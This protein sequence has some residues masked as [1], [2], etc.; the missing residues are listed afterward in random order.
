MLQIRIKNY[1]DTEPVI[2]D[3]A[4][5]RVYSTAINSADEGISFEIAKSDP[6]SEVVNPNTVGYTKLWEV[7]DTATNKRLNYGPISSIDDNIT[8]WKVSGGGRS[9]L[10]ADFIT[11][12]KTFYAPIY[13]IIEDISYENLAAQPRTTTLVPE[14]TTSAAQTTVFGNTVIINERYHGLSKG[15]KDNA[16]DDNLGLFKPGELE[17]PNTYYAHDTFWSGMDV[18]DSHIVDLGDVYDVHRI[19]YYLPVWGG[20]RKAHNRAYDY[21]VAI[22]TDDAPTTSL[23][24]REFGTFITIYTSDVPNRVIGGVMLYIGMN[25][26]S[27]QAV[28]DL[29]PTSPTVLNLP[30][31]PVRY[32]RI[33]ISDTHAWYGTH[34]DTLAATDIW[35]YECDPDYVEG[36]IPSL[37]PGPSIGTKARM[38]EPINERVL[39]P[40]NDCHAS[41]TEV[42]VNKEIV[43]INEIK[44][45]AL[46]RIDNNNPQIQYSYSPVSGK[47]IT[48]SSGFRKFEPGSLFRK[49]KVTYSGA[50]GGYT[51][52]FDSDCTNCYPDGFNFGIMDQNNSL[53]YATDTGSGTNVSRTLGAYTK[54]ILMKG[55]SN[56]VVTWCDAWPARSDPLSWGGSYSYNEV[57]GDYAVIH[58]RGQSFKWYATVPSGKTGANVQVQIRSKSG[59]GSWSSYTTLSTF[60]LPNNISNEL[61]FQI[62]YESGTLVADTS[63]EIKITNQD[64]NFCSID[65]IE[66]YW[67]ASMVE[68]NED[69]SRIFISNPTRF[70]QIYD[71]R[72]S[73]G[74]MYKIDEEAWA[75]IGFTG[76]RIIVTSAKG[77]NHGKI[78]V[79]LI[80]KGI[81]Q[82]LY[83]PGTDLHV[84]IP[85]GEPDGS[86]LIDLDTGKTGNEIPQYVLF[87]SADYFTSGLPW[88]RYSLG[89]Y[90]LKGDIETYT[91]NT[92]DV[93]FDSFVSRCSD[94]TP[95]TG[96]DIT[97]NK[98]V[99]LDGVFVHELIGLS[100]S[101]ENE[102]HLEVLKSVAEALQVEW[103]VDADGILLDPRIGT[104][105][106]VYLREGENTLVN[107]GIVN[108]VSQMAS[109]LLSS[110]ADIDGLPLF[111]ITENKATR[112][113]L[114]RTVMRQQDFRNSADYFQLVGLSRSELRRRAY[115]EKRITVSHIA[116]NLGLNQGDSFKLW[117]KRAGTIQVRINRLEINETS[118]RVYNLECVTWPQM[119]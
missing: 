2:L 98:P 13:G 31:V 35:P 117:T 61:V 46:Q 109:I 89:I 65:S 59:S 17:P 84:N 3:R 32:I 69:S 79:S 7:W 36:S 42:V 54:H 62:P 82:G 115:P 14:V 73:G 97:V 75:L 88:D 21:E 49:I 6:K 4:T 99:F 43:N 96:D 72:F 92:A 77:R 9:S 12:K 41:V 107:W 23:Q 44:Q 93:E 101:F 24:D 20:P 26:N 8:T 114:G 1:D 80:N 83:D 40:P 116:N 81:A 113:R 60:T 18:A 33:K 47:T 90:Y 103:S 51:K 111:T 110:G 50:G 86:L 74:S 19:V 87:D 55:A 57:A 78:R 66:G 27:V 104:D 106:E 48:T 37:D 112:E 68:Y 25:G 64:G 85:G 38:K 22:A 15:T 91:S 11:T 119:V 39:E 45:L 28:A 52:F 56:A 105:T 94:C 53:V 108:D 118:G 5:N 29:E 67:S 16:I 30:P 76:D 95:P 102:T 71:K 100:V 58:F 70:K 10:L 63:Y 34:F